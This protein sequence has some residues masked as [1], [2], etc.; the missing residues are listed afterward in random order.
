MIYENK[1]LAEAKGDDLSF[2]A[3]ED[4]IKELENYWAEKAPN[5]DIPNV[6]FHEKMNRVNPDTNV[7]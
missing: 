4:N 3:V 7:W 6:E 1:D 5:N 2:C